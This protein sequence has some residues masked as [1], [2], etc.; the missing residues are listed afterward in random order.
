METLK[1]VTHTRWDELPLDHVNATFDR[2]LVSGEHITIA[3]V[4]LKKG[5]GAPKH[6]HVNEQFSYVMRGTL[7]FWIGDDEQVLDVKGGEVLHLPPNVP[8]RAEALDD[9]FVV[10]VFSPPRHDWVNRTD[11]YLRK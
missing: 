11:A 4:Y 3:Q 2:R 5:G 10:D 7:R 8:H 1:P 9:V 6:G